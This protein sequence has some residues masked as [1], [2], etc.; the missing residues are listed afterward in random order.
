MTRR[1]VGIG[2][3]QARESREVRVVVVAKRS[4]VIII[5][6]SLTQRS[7]KIITKINF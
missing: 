1:V 4:K 6:Y 3:G 7:P 2:R 5:G